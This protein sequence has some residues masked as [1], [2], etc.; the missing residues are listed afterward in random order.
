MVL[1]AYS[2]ISS[3]RLLATMIARF[4]SMLTLNV[5]II[6]RY[7]WLQAPCLRR[8][9]WLLRDLKVTRTTPRP[10]P[11][12]APVRLPP[13]AL[14]QRSPSTPNQC[15]VCSFYVV[16]IVRQFFDSFPYIE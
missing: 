15:T 16:A 9:G 10:A 14:W 7:W 2:A 4:E 6:Y 3:L 11:C 13:S 5:G 8:Y 12:L 1:F